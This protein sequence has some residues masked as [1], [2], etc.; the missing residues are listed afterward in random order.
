MIQPIWAEGNIAN[1]STDS[2]CLHSDHPYADVY[3]EVMNIFIN[4]GFI[5]PNSGVP[6]K[7]NL[8]GSTV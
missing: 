3:P 1:M 4:G 5:V 2:F 6:S 8:V 7:S